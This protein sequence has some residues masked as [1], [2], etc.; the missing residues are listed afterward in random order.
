MRNADGIYLLIKSLKR[1]EKNRFRQF[2]ES[3]G[4][5]PKYLLLFDMIEKNTVN[6]HDDMLLIHKL[7]Y[8]NKN[9]FYVTKNYLFE[10]I[11]KSL[12]ISQYNNSL[13]DVLRNR[14]LS[15]KI[16]YEKT[17]FRKAYEILK[18]AKK[19]SIQTENYHRLLEILKWEKNLVIEGAVKGHKES[20]LD[21]LSIEE[22]RILKCIGNISRY[23]MLS[24]KFNSFVRSSGNKKSKE[25]KTEIKQFL[26]D[27]LI[28]NENNAIT[29][30]SKIT[31]LEITASLN[32]L[33]GHDHNVYIL[34]KKMIETLES[35][36][37]FRD[38]N[39]TNY[40]ISL[41]NFT[42]ICLSLGYLEETE[43]CI[44]KLRNISKKNSRTIA[45]NTLLLINIGTFRQETGM[46]LKKGMF[47]H[48]SSCAFELSEI[49][50]KYDKVLTVNEK[51]ES[52][53]L[54]AQ[55]LF[56][57]G[58]YDAAFAKINTVNGYNPEFL[59]TDILI[60][61]K[62]LQILLL[63]ETDKFETAEYL[64]QSIQRFFI[65]TFK[66]EQ[67]KQK[68]FHI[69]GELLKVIKKNNNI[70]QIKHQLSSLIE[71]ETSVTSKQYGEALIRYW[72]NRK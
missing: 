51:A 15:I 19:L 25:I 55:A 32:S 59:D 8:N 43:E 18:K 17:L 56:L 67:T 9:T 22:D 60:E 35:N 13:E 65:K 68:E 44:T 29:L 6:S 27:P 71:Q 10:L 42:N 3:S 50:K 57:N 62:L 28:K 2:A 61:L 41:Y 66:N 53:V 23:R 46:F 70:K 37:I 69:A 26:E 64:A 47:K 1:G 34:R 52:L 63:A 4:E 33:Q 36:S 12:C 30:A 40:V 14:I 24:F 21:N 45:Q 16:L 54:S 48:A 20:I 72:L 7:R 39:V 5:E 11:L 49:I 58:E 38:E 31:L